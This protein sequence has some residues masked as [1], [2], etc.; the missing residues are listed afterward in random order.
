MLRAWELWS[1][2]EYNRTKVN[3]V[4]GGHGGLESLGTAKGFIVA[5]VGTSSKVGNK[6]ELNWGPLGLGVGGMEEE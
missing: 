5:I 1:V 2:V 3:K 6:E 4:R